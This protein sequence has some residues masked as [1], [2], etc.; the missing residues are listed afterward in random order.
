MIVLRPSLQAPPS[1]LNL[2]Q[3]QHWGVGIYPIVS[4]HFAGATV[5]FPHR[6][7]TDT[8]PASF[9]NTTANHGAHSWNVAFRGCTGRR[10][11]AGRRRRRIYPRAG[12]PF[13][14]GGSGKYDNDNGAHP[15]AE[16]IQG[17]FFDDFAT[18]DV[19]SPQHSWT[20]VLRGPVAGFDGVFPLDRALRSFSCEQDL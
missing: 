9:G 10:G 16:G 3:P 11:C 19:P 12:G 15:S 17:G 1:E 2:L 5:V 14:D 4:L 6:R 18:M 13:Q 7:Q 8:Q 20:T